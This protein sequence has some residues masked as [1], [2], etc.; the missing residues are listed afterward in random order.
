MEMM[1]RS[2]FVVAF[3]AAF[4]M[5]TSAADVASLEAAF[6]KV[7]AVT[8]GVCIVTDVSLRLKS[9]P[10][11]KDPLEMWRS[12]AKESV[13]VTGAFVRVDFTL[14]P[15]KG[16]DIKCRAVLPLPERWDGRLWGQGNSGRAGSLPGLD[17]YIAMD[18]A[19]VTT[20]LG[21]TVASKK[22]HDKSIPWAEGVLRDFHW[23][24]PKM[25]SASSV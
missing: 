8:D 3:A 9:D 23:R 12:E 11:G 10:K 20:D 13:S 6:A 7:R 19:A 18:T 21:T 24:G 17:T 4:A 2:A 22:Y 5:G 25:R 15:E 14:V 16:S 1:T